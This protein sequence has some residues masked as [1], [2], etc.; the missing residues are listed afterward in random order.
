MAEGNSADIRGIILIGVSGCGKT[1]IGR[2]L[3]GHLGWAFIEGDEYH[4]TEN[5][6]KMASGIPLNDGDRHPWLKALHDHLAQCHKKNQPVVMACSALK[7]RYRDVLRGNQPGIHFVYLEGDFDL[8]YARMQ[9][10]AHFMK[11]DMLQSQ[12]DT[13]EKPE[14]A[15]VVDIR[16]TPEIIISQIISAYNLVRKPNKD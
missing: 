4:S 7:E 10:R 15:L 5:I 2:L 16:E 1:S 11:M 9:A 14:D 8:I 12:F 13:L 6:R 3:A